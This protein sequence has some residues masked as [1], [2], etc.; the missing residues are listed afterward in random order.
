MCKLDLTLPVRAFFLWL[1]VV[2][3]WFI[4]NNRLVFFIQIQFDIECVEPL[5]LFFQLVFKG[6][7]LLH[8]LFCGFKLCGGFLLS[9][10][11]GFQSCGKFGN[12]ILDSGEVA[13]GIRFECD[14]SI[15]AEPDT[16]HGLDELQAKIE[17]NDNKLL[18][19]IELLKELS[20]GIRHGTL[21]IT[22]LQEKG[23]D[24]PIEE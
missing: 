9:G 19:D 6:K 5:R 4:V 1:P 17:Q 18:S 10:L 14:F 2:L 3:L 13:E 21:R 11:G 24:P 7:R 16:E 23:G 20:Y 12:L 22:E 15:A 8:F